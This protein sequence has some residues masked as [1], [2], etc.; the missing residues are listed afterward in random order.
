MKHDVS[1]LPFWTNKLSAIS[2]LKSNYF[3]Y[4]IR[5]NIQLYIFKSFKIRFSSHW[6][7]SKLIDPFR[8]LSAVQLI[9]LTPLTNILAWFQP[10]PFHFFKQTSSVSCARH[11]NIYDPS[12]PTRSWIHHC[13]HHFHLSFQRTSCRPDETS[14][15]IYKCRICTSIHVRAPEEYADMI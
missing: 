15:T 11:Y 14:L 12:H 2:D 13:L 7:L 10:S 8:Y 6:P 3:S 5:D 4:F 9:T 1:S